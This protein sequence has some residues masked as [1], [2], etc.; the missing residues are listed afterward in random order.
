MELVGMLDSPYVRRVAVSL[1]L[2]GLP[3]QLRPLSVFST[4]D[5]FRAINPVVKAPTL[6]TD[7]GAVLMDSSLILDYAEQLPGKRRS[8]MPADLDERVR[9]LRVTGFALAACEKAVQ[10]VYERKLRPADK[11]HAPWLQRVQTQLQAACDALEAELV[12]APLPSA[13][14]IFAPSQAWLITI[15][16]KPAA[17]RRR[18]CQPISGSPP[19]W[20]RGLGQVSVSGRMR[21]PR[22]AANIMAFMVYPLV[23]C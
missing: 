10:L 17:L 20:S 14:S 11:Q 4:F 19:A 13:A 23:F 12:A 15:S 8:L 18:R 2:M 5:Q 7:G 6:I 22:P 3:F 9:V 1:G 16:V 21:S